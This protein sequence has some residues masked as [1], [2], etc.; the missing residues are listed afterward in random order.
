VRYLPDPRA[1][2][3]PLTGDDP[4]AAAALDAAQLAD[5]LDC[6]ERR[7]R[8]VTAQRDAL[9]GSGTLNGAGVDTG[10]Q[11][12]AAYEASHVETCRASNEAADRHGITAPS[13]R[14]AL[15]D[16]MVGVMFAE[17]ERL[18]PVV[19]ALRDALR[20]FGQHPPACG[21]ARGEPCDCSLEALTGG[22]GAPE[23]TRDVERASLRAEVERLRTDAMF[24]D[25]AIASANEQLADARRR[26]AAHRAL[27]DVERAVDAAF[28][29][30]WRAATPEQAARLEAA[31]AEM[32]VLGETT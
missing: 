11:A 9:R 4:L 24:A 26:L 14:K 22:K 21:R 17:R 29:D 30:T 20:R 12:D 23:S 19:G 2:G 18:E 13:K 16:V 3:V 28:E 1:Q 8:A 32:G 15:R 31:R 6:T 27:R 7:L 5:L 10:R 25:A